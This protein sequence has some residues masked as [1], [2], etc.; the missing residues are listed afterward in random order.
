MNEIRDSIYRVID[1]LYRDS[2]MY[3]EIWMRKIAEREVNR[4]RQKGK[5]TEATNYELRLEMSGPSFRIRWMKVL[6]VRHGEKYTRVVKSIPVPESCQYKKKNFPKAEDWELEIIL[7]IEEGMASVRKQLKHLMK[8]H[9]SLT[10]A[11]KEKGQSLEVLPLRSR[12]EP[13]N[14]SIKMFKNNLLGN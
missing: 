6:F 5:S 13:R 9:Q 14:I 4:S 10:Y 2:Q 7:M 3:Q 8:S 1:E 12:I 11:A